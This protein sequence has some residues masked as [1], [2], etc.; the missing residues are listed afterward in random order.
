MKVR[1]SIDDGGAK[2]IK[3]ARLCS[4]YGLE[5]IFYWP[6]DI[7]GLGMS[8][9]WETI[10]P[11]AESYI[12]R[13]FEI[14]SHGITHRYLTKIPIEEAIDEIKASK[15]MLQ[16][17][18]DTEITKF[19]YPRGYANDEIK[20]VVKDAGYEYARS[21]Q[22]GSIGEPDDPFFASTAVHM[23][24]PVRPEYKGTTWFDYGM[25]MFQKA[26]DKN[27]DFEGWMHS[28]EVDRYNEWKNVER[29]IKAI[30]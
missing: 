20:Q 17:K 28:W 24:C 3:I 14:G 22:I 9:G 8:K 1:I 5:A 11:Q 23:G 4:K 27:V 6:V 7:L 12:A 19:C 29:F 26:K 10:N 2:D 30:T 25:D 21:T 16:N 18:Y 13:T 15:T